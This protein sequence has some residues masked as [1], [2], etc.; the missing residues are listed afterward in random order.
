MGA[1]IIGMV[2]ITLAA[3]GS[4]TPAPPPPISNVA[5]RAPGDAAVDAAPTG[6][7]AVM[8]KMSQFADDMCKCSDR[9]CAELVSQ[10][11]IKWEYEMTKSSGEPPKMSEP[12]MEEMVAVAQRLSKCMTDVYS[13][14][15][16]SG[17][18]P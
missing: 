12:D 11:M 13:I 15:A 5:P 18:T 6:N 2:A 9:A 8:A 14:G 1:T 16:G 3:C 17:S 7:A 4:T 10:Q